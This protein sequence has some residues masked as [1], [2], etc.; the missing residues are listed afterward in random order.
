[1]GLKIL[2]MFQMYPC[3]H[4]LKREIL[5]AFVLEA[6]YKWQACIHIQDLFVNLNYSI[7]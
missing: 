2:S 6:I 5:I 1:M 7:C 4:Y 3:S